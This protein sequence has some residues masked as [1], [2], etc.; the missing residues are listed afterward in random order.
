MMGTGFLATVTAIALV[1]AAAPPASAEAVDAS[2]V[3]S[4]ARSAFESA[5]SYEPARTS[6]RFE[7]LDAS[8]KVVSTES[9]ETVVRWSS[10]ARKT[11]ILKAERDG[12]DVRAD[13]EKRYARSDKK[14]DDSPSAGPP[15]G[16]DATPFDPKYASGVTRGAAVSRGGVYEIPYV[17][18]T[19]GGPVEGVARFSST[20]KVLSI[21]QRWT[22]PPFYIAYMSMEMGYTYHDGALVVSSMKA[23][24]EASVLMVKRRFRMALEFGDWQRKP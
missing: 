15:A 21:S 3:W 8:G 9:G 4:A 13:W 23:E 10:G 6:L 11:V 22:D 2:E 12:K 14:D 19:D 24:G 16:F 17:I 20:G 18:T 7:Q 1:L 5:A